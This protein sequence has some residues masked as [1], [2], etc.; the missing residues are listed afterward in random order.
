MTRLSQ[1]CKYFPNKEYNDIE[2]KQISPQP[3]PCKN[4][5][6]AEFLKPLPPTKKPENKNK[7]DENNI[8]FGNRQKCS[9]HPKHLKFNS[10]KDREANTPHNRSVVVES[11]ALK[12]LEDKFKNNPFDFT[13]IKKLFDIYK[14][15]GMND[16]LTYIRKHTLK[17]LPLPGKLWVEWLKDE[18]A[19]IKTKHNNSFVKRYELI[20]MF[21]Q[22]LGD[23]YCIILK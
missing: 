12:N 3:L 13:T 7:E 18:I 8:H 14:K 1:N 4:L 20:T 17:C 19:D 6:E 2:M 23:F 16:K 10:N 21:K 9:T 5:F 15:K 11:F 22:A